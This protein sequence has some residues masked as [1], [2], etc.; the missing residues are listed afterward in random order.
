[1]DIQKLLK[2]FLDDVK[3]HELTVNLD[4]GVYRDLTVKNPNTVVMHYNITTRPGYLMITGDMGSFIFNRTEDMFSFFR[5]ELPYQINP[6][7]WGEK[8][9][10]GVIR[11][12]D[13]GTANSSLQELL[14]DYLNGLDLSDAD[15]RSKSKQALDAVNNFISE[16]QG[17]SEFDFWANINYWDENEAGGLD[18]S[19]FFEY[20]TTKATFNYIWC[21]YAIVHAI[22][23]YDAYVEKSLKE[24]TPND[25]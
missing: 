15:D 2:Q 11:E 7:Y 13:I 25:I 23:L 1:M 8:V 9:K 24:E 22:K 16:N 14:T 5:S 3:T 6:G 10:S 12:F 18:L 20:P 21:C 4:Q 17:S 19:D